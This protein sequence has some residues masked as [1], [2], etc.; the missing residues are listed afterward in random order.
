MWVREEEHY[1]DSVGLSDLFIVTDT[2][3]DSDSEKLLFGSVFSRHHHPRRLMGTRESTRCSRTSP[4]C[5]RL[6]ADVNRRT[7][8]YT[9]SAL[10][11]LR[12]RSALVNPALSLPEVNELFLASPS[13]SPSPARLYLPCICFDPQGSLARLNVCPLT[14]GDG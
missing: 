10:A 8:A 14:K 11:A 1:W 5:A 12:E 3:G 13:P 4:A 9:W 6:Y 7:L 2:D